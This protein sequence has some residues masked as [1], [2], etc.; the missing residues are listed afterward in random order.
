MIRI[1]F[2][3]IFLFVAIAGS[4]QKRQKKI[5]QFAGVVFSSDT[6][7]I[8]P[9]VH[10]YIPKSGR[11]TTTNPY[12]FFSLPVLEGD[13]LIISSV[14]FK[15]S[16]FIIPEY[17][18]MDKSLKV[19]ITLE[20]DIKFLEEV[21]ITPFPTERLFK[22]AIISMKLPESVE[23]ANIY[24]WLNSEVLTTGYL[25]IPSSPSENL[26]IFEQQRLQAQANRYS[27][28]INPFA[29]PFAWTQFISSL[30]KKKK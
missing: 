25:N 11:G 5:I 6:T 17:G 30:K 8:V 26:R 9:G 18:D 12:G 16:Y 27:P 15:K 7:S 2:V 13:S 29:N 14:G 3:V 22:E 20:E 19:V 4:A 10:I 21:E 1:I 23:Y 24:Q 28:L